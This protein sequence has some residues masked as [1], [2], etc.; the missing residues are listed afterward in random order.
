[1]NVPDPAQVT[2]DVLDLVETDRLVEALRRR[3]LASVIALA[4]DNAK[5]TAENMTLYT[6]G[7]LSASGLALYAC[8]CAAKELTA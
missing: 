8:A 1:M 2:D 3:S 4:R 6:S 7:G 5:S